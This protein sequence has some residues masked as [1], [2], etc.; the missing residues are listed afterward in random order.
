MQ[1]KRSPHGL[2]LRGVNCTAV[3]EHGCQQRTRVNTGVS[4]EYHYTSL[5]YCNI[6]VTMS[7]TQRSSLQGLLPNS[8]T[9]RRKSSTQEVRNTTRDCAQKDGPDLPLLGKGE[10]GHGTDGI[11]EGQSVNTSPPPDLVAHEP[12]PPPPPSTQ[13]D[14]L[15][16]K[17]TESNIS[18][19]KSKSHDLPTIEQ[20]ISK[21]DR[22]DVGVI[23]DALNSVYA[24]LRENHNSLNSHIESSE[25]RYTQLDLKIHKVYSELSDL[26]TVVAGHERTLKSLEVSKASREQFQNLNSKVD[27]MKRDME[28]SLENVRST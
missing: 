4:G 24:L 17:T 3:A 2:S 21:K 10:S 13:D 25:K 14:S 26:N 6:L 22:G 5:F 20:L 12:P 23:S 7:Q 18:L 27:S 15:L 16:G 9:I 1:A 11:V 19:D 28:S 8:I